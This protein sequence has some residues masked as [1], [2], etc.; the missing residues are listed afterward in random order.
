MISFNDHFVYYVF[1]KVL[2]D[3]HFMFGG[4]VFQ[5]RSQN[6]IDIV[7]QLTIDISADRDSDNEEVDDRDDDCSN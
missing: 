3:S 5:S 7:D 4:D 6:D 1:K 2:P